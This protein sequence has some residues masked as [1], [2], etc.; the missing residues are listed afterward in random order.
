MKKKWKNGRRLIAG[1]P[2]LTICFC[3]KAKP[4]KWEKGP[5]KETLLK[6]HKLSFP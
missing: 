2:N 1:L 5:L 6:W 3:I 4:S